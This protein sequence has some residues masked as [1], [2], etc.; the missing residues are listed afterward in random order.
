MESAQK[1]QGYFGNFVG[2]TL[3]TLSFF[4]TYKALALLN[5]LNR[6][7]ANFANT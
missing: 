1:R 7:C 5:R 4:P 3:E 2:P 6:K